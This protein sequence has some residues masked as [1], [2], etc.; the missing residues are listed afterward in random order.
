[1]TNPNKGPEQMIA[2]GRIGRAHGVRG[3]VR[4]KPYGDDP[5][6]LSAY[7]P[8]VD[9]NGTSYAIKVL[10]I[11]KDVA[12]SR[13][14]G[15]DSRDAVE[16]LNGVELFIRRD[17]LPNEDEPDTFYHADLVG[18]EAR[19]EA[20]GLLGTLV[21]AHDFGAGDLLEIAPKAGKTV[22]V[23]FTKEA[24]PSV[25]FGEGFVTIAETGLFAPDDN[26]RNGKPE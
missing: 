3:D 6:A 14:K 11:S 13:I 10:R 24:V 18:L 8:L 7:G 1:M 19:D 17:Q 9:K 23:P 2:M 5:H 26:D 20:G 16:A 15:V 22:L 4:I 12:I 25:N 21:A